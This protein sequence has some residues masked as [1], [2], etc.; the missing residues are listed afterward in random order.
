[1]RVVRRVV[2]A[3]I[4]LAV[5]TLS[6][7][8]LVEVV[9][10]ALGRPAW[11]VDEQRIRDAL[12]A[13]QW[14]DPDVLLA[15]GVVL[16]LGLGLLAVAVARGRPRTVVLTSDGTDAALLRVRRRSLERYLA[17]VAT[18]QPGVHGARAAVRR[19]RVRVRADSASGEHRRRPRAGAPGRQRPCAVAGPQP[20]PGH[21][22]VR[23]LA[24]GLR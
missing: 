11:V 23:P 24:G 4:A 16:L 8:T 12:G 2:S 13:R 5:I 9:L 20:R 22:R 21:L 14:D 3:V 17:G 18:A 6:V 1:M 19:G 10:L 7:I 15:W